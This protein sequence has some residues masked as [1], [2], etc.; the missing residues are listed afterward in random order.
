MFIPGNIEV[1]HNAY[2]TQ[3][4][5]EINGRQ[6]ESFRSE[7]WIEAAADACETDPDTESDD[8][9]RA[10]PIV[11]G[12]VEKATPSKPE[13]TFCLAKMESTLELTFGLGKHIALIELDKVIPV[14]VRQI[15]WSVVDPS[16]GS[17]TACLYRGECG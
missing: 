1:C 12:D 6:A 15:E 10:D 2:T 13:P 3:L 11:G 7:R 4:R 9:L 14:L 5:K 17:V 16:R 8:Q